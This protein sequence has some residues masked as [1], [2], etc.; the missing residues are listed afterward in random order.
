MKKI[1][2][3]SLVL[4]SLF[5]AC[6][7]NDVEFPNYDYSTVYFAYQSPVRTLVMGEDDF[8]DT[9]LD[10]EHKCKIMATIGGVYENKKKVTIDYI[11]DEGLCNNLYFKLNDNSASNQVK[12]MPKN[13]YSLSNDV[14]TLD[15]TMMGGVEVSLTDAFFEDPETK[16]NTYV[17]P[18][19]MVDVAN[20]DS[21]LLGRT[22]FDNPIWTNTQQ[23][24]VQ[25]K[26][27][28]LYCIKYINKYDAKYIRRGTDKIIENGVE[29]DVNRITDYIEDGEICNVN[30]STLNKALFP[31]K[32]RTEN[33]GELNCE[34][35][36]T[37]DENDECTITT[38]TPGY[39]VEGNG[40]FVIDGDKNSWGN[41]DRNA[42]FLNYTVK[43]EN[44]Q[45]V[46]EDILVVQTR[47]VKSEEF[48][49]EY[50]E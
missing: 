44:V 41:K 27:Y 33:S 10:N 8:F 17:I 30:T 7:N 15:K 50:R 3:Y 20:A 21:I 48:S 12:V 45:C 26:N 25:P 34:L 6:K 49:F 18:L 13:Y 37:F 35:I 47:N 32:I 4:M 42:L 40:R 1:L 43:Y 46:T 9:T 2:L 28:I 19:R 31:L 23:W 14:I 38:E 36:L 39:I 22:D 16:E 5:S 29:Y 24:S 11:V